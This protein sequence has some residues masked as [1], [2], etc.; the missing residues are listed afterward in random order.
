[1]CNC[2]G[3]VVGQMWVWG[4]LTKAEMSTSLANRIEAFLAPCRRLGTVVPSQQLPT[5]VGSQ[6][7]AS[8]PSAISDLSKWFARAQSYR[9]PGF[10]PGS[11]AAATGDSWRPPAS[12][13]KGQGRAVGSSPG[14]RDEESERQL[15]QDLLP[16]PVPPPSAAHGGQA[17][18]SEP[19]ND[20]A[21]LDPAARRAAMAA[22]AEA[23]LQGAL[24]TGVA[25]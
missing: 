24:G 20:S 8:T 21:A 16:V 10:S 11:D 25:R 2:A 15:R 14:G 12:S 6:P 23:R 3:V 4:W 7:H 13:F 22:A 18:A 17:P 1:M 9:I 19:A 5:T